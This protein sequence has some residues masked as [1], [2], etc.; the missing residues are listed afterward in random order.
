MLPPCGSGVAVLQHFQ[1][2]FSPPHTHTHTTS[3][4]QTGRCM[5]SCCQRSCVR[6]CR[7]TTP[8]PP[9]ESSTASQKTRQ[10]LTGIWQ[11]TCHSRSGVFD[12]VAVCVAVVVGMRTWR[13]WMWRSWIWKIGL[14][15]S[16]FPL[17][18]CWWFTALCES[19]LHA[20]CCCVCVSCPV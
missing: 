20:G 2:Q 19:Q 6:P 9:A 17:R 11:A 5:R 16:C 4:H 12:L 15:V 8:R 14:G 7:S 18:S 1:V 3:T 10:T 13:S